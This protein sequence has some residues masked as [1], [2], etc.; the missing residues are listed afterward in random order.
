MTWFILT[1]SCIIIWGITDIFYK[2]ST[3]S[4][5]AFPHFKG[6]IW[7][8]IVM[9]AAGAV[10]AFFSDTFH[11]SLRM[12]RY[13]FYLIPVSFLYPVALIFGIVGKKHLDASVVSPIENIDGAMASIIMYFYFLFSGYKDVISGFGIMDIAGTAVIVFGMVL[14]GLQEQKMKKQEEGISEGKRKHRLGA[15]VL[16]FPI[17]YNL[18]DAVS[19]AATG[20]TINDETSYNI[21]DIDFFIFESFSFTVVACVVWLYMLIVKKHFYNPFRKSESMRSAAAFGETFG[22]MTFIFATAI[23]PILT[24]SV[25]SSYCL[26]TILAAH[27][28][29]KERLSGKQYFCLAL[30]IAGIALLGISEITRG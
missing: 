8:G 14:L 9:A 26:V 7:V 24:A 2:K 29:L 27:I 22:T 12:L 5:D 30:L 10:M 25:T 11:E 19:M 16:I 20:I 3:E 23:N 13:N 28:F 4:D 18:V 17:L 21:P 15:L 6:L 1:V